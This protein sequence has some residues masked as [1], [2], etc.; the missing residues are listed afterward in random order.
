MNLA[1]NISVGEIHGPARRRVGAI[2]AIRHAQVQCTHPEHRTGGHIFGPA[3][4]RGI[5]LQCPA[6][7]QAADV[8]V[9]IVV[10]RVARHDG[11]DERLAAGRRMLGNLPAAGK[12]SIVKM[13]REVESVGGHG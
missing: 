11:H 7:M 13:G 8:V 6:C 9:R 4:G 1:K 12:R 10:G 3:P 2:D 5:T